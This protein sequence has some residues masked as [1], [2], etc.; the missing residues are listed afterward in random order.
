M[1]FTEAI[2]AARLAGRPYRYAASLP[3][4]MDAARAWLLDDAPHGAMVIAGEQTA[5]RGRVGRVWLNSGG[6][7]L[8]CSVI[9][10][11][12]VALLPHASMFGGLVVLDMLTTLGVP[13]AQLKWP[14]DVLAGGRKI[15][16]VLVEPIWDG[17]VL[18]GAVLGIG[19]N[20]SGTF[21]DAEIAATATTIADMLGQ[22]P[23]LSTVFST[24][25][26]S[27]DR[28]LPD[29]HTS[30]LVHALRARLGTIGQRVRIEGH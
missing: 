3:S 30:Q 17:A 4:T 8:A 21:A 6:T 25:V 2:V 10:R 15:C 19:V 14:N 11:M 28:R 23:V 20:V 5:G 29:L 1:T 9:L 13:D 27:F 18:R 24:F 7:A 12:T 26:E 16:G 22:P